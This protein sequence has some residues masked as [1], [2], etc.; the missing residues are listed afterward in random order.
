MQRRRFEPLIKSKTE[1]IKSHA[2][3]KQTLAAGSENSYDLWCEVQHLPKLH[4]LFLKFLFGLL[5]VVYV[6]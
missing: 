4:L 2:V 5:A 1:V 6:R 3:G